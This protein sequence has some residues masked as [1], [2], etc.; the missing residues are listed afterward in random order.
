MDGGFWDYVTFGK[1]T[2]LKSG[3]GGSYKMEG[4]VVKDTGA[5]TSGRGIKVEGSGH[6]VTG[7]SMLKMGDA[8][9]ECEDQWDRQIYEK[10]YLGLDDTNASVVIEEGK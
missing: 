1:D 3:S 10:G 4:G 7:K 6:I 2:T 9:C 8:L 5:K